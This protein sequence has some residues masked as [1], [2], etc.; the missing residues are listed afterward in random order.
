M[1]NI[2]FKSQKIGKKRKMVRDH[3]QHELMINEYI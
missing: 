3:Y 1:W 2:D